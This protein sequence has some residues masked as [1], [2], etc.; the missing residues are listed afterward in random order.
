MKK[1]MPFEDKVNK[2]MKAPKAM[3]MKGAMPALAKKAMAVVAPK[4]NVK[5]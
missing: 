5:R 1:M 4:T 3:K 2:K